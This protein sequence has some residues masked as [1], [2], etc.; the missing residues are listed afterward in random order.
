M[1][2]AAL[3]VALSRSHN[4]EKRYGPSPANNYTSGSGKRKFWAR[5][6]QKNRDAELGTLGAAE[7]HKHDGL[8]NGVEDPTL[9][10]TAVGNGY[11]G[12]D[13][14]Y[15]TREPTVPSTTHT[16]TSTMT[17]YTPQGTGYQSTGYVPQTS[18]VIGGGAGTSVPEM[19]A[20]THSAGGQV[21]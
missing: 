5:K 20:H 1:V 10:G 6:N 4:R 2:S 18:G 8:N 17:G 14:K 11:G 12:P 3:Q 16:A 19:P 13:N 7:H 21:Y 9:T 15:A